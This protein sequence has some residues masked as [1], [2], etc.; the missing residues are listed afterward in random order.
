MVQGIANASS[1]S[2][3]MMGTHLYLANNLPRNCGVDLLGKILLHEEKIF[4][5]FRI[6]LYQVM[7]ATIAHIQNNE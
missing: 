2:L 3:V 7:M 1:I 4:F 6:D 5:F